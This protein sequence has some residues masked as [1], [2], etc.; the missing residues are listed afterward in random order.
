MNYEKI[1]KYT[2]LVVLIIGALL[3]SYLFFKYIL[4]YT[5]PFLIGWFLAF[6]IRPPSRFVAKKLKVK[7][8]AVRLILTILVFLVGLGI[9]ALVIWLLSREVWE[10]I[11]GIGRGDS[12]FDEF[13]SGLTSPEGLFGR[14]FGNFSSYVADALYSVFTSMLNSFGSFVSSAVS[15]IPKSLLFII[16]TVIASAYFAVGLEEVNF[17]VKRVLPKNVTSMLVRIKDGFLS[18]LLKYLRSY[19]LLL[20]I[21]FIEMLVGLFLLRA[22]YPLVMA[23]VIAV[24]DLLPVIGVG[25][26][27]IPWGVWSF[28]IGRTPFGIGLLVLFAFHTVLRQV[29]EP[30]IVGKNLG[31]HPLLTLVF[32]YVGYSVFGFI[33]IVLVPIFTVL[34]NIAFGKKDTAEVREHTT[35]QGDNT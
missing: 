10:L 33:G 12:S 11:A 31:M 14:L 6:A 9:S 29:I 34:V 16:I 8:K 15:V 18:T 21:T 25:F 1:K 3:L 22:P 5:L 19:L 32:I 13:I 30:K 23:I 20:L 17:A 7:P 35:G 27:L 24:L 4:I 28:V 2:Y 26:V